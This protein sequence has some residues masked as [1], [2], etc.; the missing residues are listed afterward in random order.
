MKKKAQLAFEM[1][2]H[3]FEVMEI[4]EQFETV[5]G[6]DTT[7]PAEDP[8]T[9]T[10]TTTATPNGWGNYSGY[11]TPSN[12]IQLEEVTVT[13]GANPGEPATNP[14]INV[15][16]ALGLGADSF[17]TSMSTAHTLN[18][19]ANG[20]AIEATAFKYV[21]GSGTI[22]GA[23]VGGGPAIINILQG[24]ATGSDYAAL[25]FAAAGGILEIT[26]WGE[27]YDGTVGVG[28]AVGNLIYDVYNY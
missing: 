1:L 4:D 15:A 22:I 28:A 20:T 9:S 27:L 11:G 6:N 12:P 18:F 19:I 5:G 25:A 14:G 23:I 16:A 7:P 10:T 3:E 8:T 13:P 17:N 26:G 21:T 2:Q 24:D